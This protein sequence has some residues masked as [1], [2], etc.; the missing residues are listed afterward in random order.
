MKIGNTEIILKHKYLKQEEKKN[1]LRIF[2]DACNKVFMNDDVFFSSEEIKE[3][4]KDK[5]NVFL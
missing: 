3:L 5:R 4:K 2:Y 1:N